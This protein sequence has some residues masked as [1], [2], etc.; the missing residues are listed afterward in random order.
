[1]LTLFVDQSISS[2]GITLSNIDDV[3]QRVHLF[4]QNIKNILCNCI[5]HNTVTCDD[6]DPSWI[7]N[8]IKVL[9]REKNIAKKCYFQNNKDIQLFRRFQ[10]IQDLLTATIEKSQE[11]F[12][13]QISTK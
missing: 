11:Q 7:N 6:R 3:N 13:S 2:L 9:I 1:M 8:K 12:Y 4:N 10:C 5:P